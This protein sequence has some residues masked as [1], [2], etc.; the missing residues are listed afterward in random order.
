[1]TSH[2]QRLAEAKC[3]C[4]S[5]GLEPPYIEGVYQPDHPSAEAWGRRC[6]HC[7]A[8]STWFAR[9]CQCHGTGALVPGL[10]RECKWT[11]KSNWSHFKIES[12]GRCGTCDDVG[13][14]LIPEAEQMGVLVKFA[15]VLRW[16]VTI[17][18]L[19]VD[20]PE[21]WRAWLHDD[22]RANQGILKYASTPEEALGH[23]IEELLDGLLY[24]WMA[25][26]QR[27]A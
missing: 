10:R 12:T 22:E 27:D 24:L 13:W 14:T 20:I 23:A 6:N 7:Q 18:H 5:H 17:R 15:A 21:P 19:Q 2:V 16:T 11:F 25:K 4:P 1:M 8:A 3:P 26:W 9:V